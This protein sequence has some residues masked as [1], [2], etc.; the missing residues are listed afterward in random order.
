ML[1]FIYASKKSTTSP[2]IMKLAN[3][4]QLYVL[5]SYSGLNN[6]GQ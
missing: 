3:A 4:L 5:I 6:V 2:I 1:K